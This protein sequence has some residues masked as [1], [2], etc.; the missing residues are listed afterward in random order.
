MPKLRK[1]KLVDEVA[2]STPP[3]E[4]QYVEPEIVSHMDDVGGDS[5]PI[6]EEVDVLPALPQKQPEAPIMT[7]EMINVETV[8]VFKLLID[9]I[10]HTTSNKRLTY[11]SREIIGKRIESAE[12]VIKIINSQ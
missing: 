1:S 4:E 9:A 2:M 11:Q 5:S 12:R 3:I 10:K 6:V 8:R 7:Q